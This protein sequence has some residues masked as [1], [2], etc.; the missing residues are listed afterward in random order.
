MSQKVTNTHSL[1]LP[2]KIPQTT[3]ALE[4][5]ITLL[6]NRTQRELKEKARQELL[7]LLDAVPDAATA[8]LWKQSLR[9]LSKQPELSQTLLTSQ[10]LTL[11]PST[12][13][14]ETEFAPETKLIL[15][16]VSQALKDYYLDDEGCYDPQLIFQMQKWLNA[17]QQ[18]HPSAFLAQQFVAVNIALS[19]AQDPFEF[20]MAASD[21]SLEEQPIITSDN[22]PSFVEPLLRQ[23]LSRVD[24]CVIGN[25]LIAQM[26]LQDCSRSTH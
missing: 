11:T 5:A 8:A 22:Q 25:Y 10:N 15:S 17:P 18:I 26:S 4:R 12:E 14:E 23:A 1:S 19:Q 21:F 2:P 24:W 20:D 16:W 13:V 7:E 6:G 9:Q 3:Q